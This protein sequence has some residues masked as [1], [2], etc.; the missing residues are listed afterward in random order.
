V[1]SN[2]NAVKRSE[3][4]NVAKNLKKG[5]ILNQGLYKRSKISV[6]LYGQR[7]S[8]QE[9]YGGAYINPHSGLRTYQSKCTKFNFF[10]SLNVIRSFC[11]TFN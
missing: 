11:I 9:P 6:L 1:S 10:I 3:F 8:M 7:I 4:E 5:K 2:R